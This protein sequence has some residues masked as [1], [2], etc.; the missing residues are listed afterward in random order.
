MAFLI[1]KQ[2]FYAQ[3][4]YRESIFVLFKTDLSY[5][6]QFWSIHVKASLVLN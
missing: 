2:P 6:R 4:I 5:V 3:S 1:K